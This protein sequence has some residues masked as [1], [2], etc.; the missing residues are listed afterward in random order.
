MQLEPTVQR[1]GKPRRGRGFSIAEL[2]EAGTDFR[3]ALKSR[4]P[5]DQRRKAKYERNIEI[6]KQYL[7]SMGSK[8]KKKS[9]SLDKKKI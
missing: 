7:Q 9:K 4:I 8:K 5:V 1:K 6:L 2:S 3:Q